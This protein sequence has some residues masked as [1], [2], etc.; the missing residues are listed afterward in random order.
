MNAEMSNDHHATYHKNNHNE[1]YY[2]MWPISFSVQCPQ[3]SLVTL[4]HM[5]HTGALCGTCGRGDGTVCT[6]DTNDFEK[7]STRSKGVLLSFTE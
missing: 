4:L 1:L 6:R 2:S 5:F 7:T 3:V